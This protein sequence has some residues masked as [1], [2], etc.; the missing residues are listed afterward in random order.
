[1]ISSGS[2]PRARGRSPGLLCS[3]PRAHTHVLGAPSR[4]LGISGVAASPGLQKRQGE[5]AG[6]LDKQVFV[7]AAV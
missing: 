1:M 6:P 4:R 2:G 7:T 5:G 3:A